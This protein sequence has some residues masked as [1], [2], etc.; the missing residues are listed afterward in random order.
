MIDVSLHKAALAAVDQGGLSMEAEFELKMS[1]IGK[2]L[3]RYAARE[4]GECFECRYLLGWHEA[5][6]AAL[7]A[8]RGE[9]PIAGSGKEAVTSHLHAIRPVEGF[10][11]WEDG[12]FDAIAW[13]RD[14]ASRN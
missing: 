11:P 2:Q 5:L 7:K 13:M 14:Y 8:Y 12:V 9:F 10:A 6:K 3:A 4:D 1:A